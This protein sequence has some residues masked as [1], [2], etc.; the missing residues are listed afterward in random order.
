MSNSKVMIIGAGLC[1]TLLGIRLAQRGH[2]VQIFEKRSDMRR[3]D[4]EA[5]RSINLALSN[6]GLRALRMVGLEGAVSEHCI[7]MYGRMIHSTTGEL[8]F[9]KYSGREGEH[10][11]SISRSGLNVAL[12]DAA[13]GMEN[14]ELHFEHQCLEVDLPAAR[15]RFRVG[16]R[17][18]EVRADVIFGADGAGSAVRRSMMAR[19]NE[20]LFNYSQFFLR[21]GYKELTI[22]PGPGG[23]YRIE[24][25]ALHIWPR[26]TYMLIALPNLDGS[27]TVTLFHPF[28]GRQG[29]K[30]LTTRRKVL[31]FFEAQFADIIPHVPGLLT[32][33]FANPN[34]NLG[35]IRCYPWQAYGKALLMGDASHAIVP[36]YGQGMNSSF[37]DVVVFDQ[38]LDTHPNNWARALEAFQEQRVGDTNAIADLAV[39]NFYEMR[40]H[41]ANPAFIRKRHLEMQLE[42]TYPDYF[43]KY[44]MVTF[45]EH[46]P[47]REALRKGR[48]QDELLMDIVE[49]QG[50]RDLDLA[51]VWEKV[52]NLA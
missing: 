36:F 33:F 28:E 25:N 4:T 35:T 27:F 14:L 51:R 37:E 17:E 16:E 24:K 52:R 42:Q 15:A 20:L 48:R 44:S 43:S 2:R 47:Y 11:N 39:D 12:L 6:R 5:G 26:G 31:D 13:E 32:D 34:S 8:R 19:T 30:A 29:L 18:H 45:N 46:L 10:I 7:P 40:D 3:A 41:V 22:P 23:S 50:D 38:V 49:E 9:S 1:G 21:H